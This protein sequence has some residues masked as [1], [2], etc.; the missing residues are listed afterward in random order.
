MC[1]DLSVSQVLGNA[2]TPVQVPKGLLMDFPF[3][4]LMQA[5]KRLVLQVAGGKVR[6][7]NMQSD[8]YHG[9][10]KSWMFVPID[11]AKPEEIITRV[12]MHLYRT[13]SS[14]CVFPGD[15]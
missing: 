2:H 13:T 7:L 9:E 15:S 1:E 11:S 8:P 4:C 10:T 14:L 6:T 5:K 12:L 3:V